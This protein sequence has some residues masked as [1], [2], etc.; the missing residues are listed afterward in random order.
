[1]PRRILTSTIPAWSQRSGANTLSA[2]LSLIPKETGVEIA[3]IF[4]RA[5]TPDSPV[6]S[7][8][9]QILEGRVVR[10]VLSRSVPTGRE[11]APEER[12][13]DADKELASETSR[14]ATFTR[15]RNQLFLWGRELLWKLGRWHTPELDRFLDDFAPDVFFFPIESYPYF[16]RVNRYVIRRCRPSLVVGYLWD[17]N[18]T[19]KQSSSL[20][21]R[22]NR[23]ITLRSVN[24]LVRQCDKIVAISPKMKRE[25]DA[26]FG[27][28]SIILTKPIRTQ[29]KPAYRRDPSR[30]IRLLYTGSLVIGRD[31]SLAAL[32]SEIAK[33]NARGGQQFFLDIY[34]K[35][36]VSDSMAGRLN[37]PG[38]SRLNPAIPQSQVFVEQ[39]N[40]DIL[41]F[42]ESF[43]DKSAR[44]SFSTKI[45]DYLSANRCILAIGPRDISSIDYLSAND[46]ALIAQT[47]ADIAASLTRLAA[48]PSQLTHY[49][50][51]AY[52]C[53]QRNHSAESIRLRLFDILNIPQKTKLIVS[54]NI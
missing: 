8:Y 5:E 26:T 50:E 30:P 3:N 41:V 33:I 38:C 42:V 7:R 12:R 37:V 31:Q 28:D 54:P 45:T 18:F 25:V 21:H 39:E 24:R 29:S 6:A 46:A 52:A 17:D 47:P 53:G 14:Y 23:W 4:C 2:I 43:T 20:V 34:T 13:P 36:A 32:V 1:M 16:N 11:L 15:H 35:T 22:I 27:V 49:A 51:K 40:A 9:F 44:L 10:S 19:Y 48:D